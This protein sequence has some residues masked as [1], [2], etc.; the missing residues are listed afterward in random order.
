MYLC[1]TGLLSIIILQFSDFQMYITLRHLMVEF[2]SVDAGTGLYKT[3]IRV[4]IAAYDPI[5]DGM[6]ILCLCPNLSTCFAAC[7]CHL[8]RAIKYPGVCALYRPYL[9]LT[10]GLNCFWK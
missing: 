8:R 6:A 2:C 7:A 4:L 9:Y 5:C 1:F 3:C 10:F